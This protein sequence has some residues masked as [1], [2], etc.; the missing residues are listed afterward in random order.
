VLSSLFLL[1]DGEA[2]KATVWERLLPRFPQLRES[3]GG[4]SNGNEL[5]SLGLGFE[6]QG[7][8]FQLGS[9]DVHR[10]GLAIAASGPI[11]VALR[12]GR[13]FVVNLLQS[14]VC[15]D[16]IVFRFARGGNL[17][18]RIR[19]GIYNDNCPFHLTGASD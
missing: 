19:L 7:R 8:K 2:P 3:S 18:A 13:V 12:L 6:V 15:A 5:E 10:G 16:S 11:Y 17:I 14:L 9:P 4:F 1:S